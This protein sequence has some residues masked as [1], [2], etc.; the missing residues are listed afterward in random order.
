MVLLL[1]NSLNSLRINIGSFIC[2]PLTVAV[3]LCSS[4]PLTRPAS[5]DPIGRHHRQVR[6]LTSPPSSSSSMASQLE[7]FSQSQFP[8]PPVAK[9]VKHVMEMF[10]DVRVD[11]YYWLRDDSRTNP[12]ML[13]YLSQENAYTESIMSGANLVLSINLLKVSI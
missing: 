1:P 2:I 13:S 3:V 6:F 5:S 10:G 9:K 11:N 7:T 12:E 8:P 4:F